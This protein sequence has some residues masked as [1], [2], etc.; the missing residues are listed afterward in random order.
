MW[1]GDKWWSWLI[2]GG[3][4]LLLYYWLTGQTT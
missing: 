4:A 1:F 3:L 2:W